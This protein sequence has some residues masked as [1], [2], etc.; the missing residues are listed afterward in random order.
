MWWPGGAQGPWYE[1]HNSPGATHDGHRVGAGRRRGRRHATAPPPTSWS[2]TPAR[3]AASVRVTVYV[4]GGGTRRPHLHRAG[5]EPLQRGRRRRLRIDGRQ[6]ADGR[7]GRE[8]GRDA[9]RRSSSSARCTRTPAAASGRPARTRWR[10]ASAELGEA[11]SGD[12]RRSAQQRLVGRELGVQRL[13]QRPPA[14]VRGER[15][16]EEADRGRWWPARRRGSRARASRAAPRRRPAAPAHAST[17]AAIRRTCTDSGKVG[18]APTRRKAA[19][20]CSMARASSPTQDARSPRSAAGATIR[21]RRPSAAARRRPR[22][23]RP[24]GQRRR[25]RRRAAVPSPGARPPASG[26]HRRSAPNGLCWTKSTGA[27]AASRV[28]STSSRPS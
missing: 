20:A 16:A 22:A 18:V 17:R 7:A 10:P 13:R 24:P 11:A 1:G 25:H 5:V 14:R 28:R 2:P 21:S 4:E 26:W 9:R 19:R 8:P 12:R 27:A 23:R 3:A 15:R 6:R